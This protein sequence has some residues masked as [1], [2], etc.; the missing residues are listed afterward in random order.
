LGRISLYEFDFEGT[1]VGRYQ[2][3]LELTPSIR[4]G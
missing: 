3:S 4:L 2:P 1:G